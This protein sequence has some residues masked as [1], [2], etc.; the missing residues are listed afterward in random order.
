[1]CR[2]AGESSSRRLADVLSTRSKVHRNSHSPRHCLHRHFLAR[3]QPL[4][5]A[6]AACCPP[7]PPSAA[8]AAAAARRRP[9]PPPPPPPPPADGPRHRPRLVPRTGGRRRA[10]SSIGRHHRPPHLAAVPPA[11]PSPA[12]RRRAAVGAV[13]SACTDFMLGAPP[14]SAGAAIRFRRW[15][16]PRDRLDA[17]AAGP[18]QAGARRADE[19]SRRRRVRRAQGPRGPW[20]PSLV[21][22]AALVAARSTVGASLDRLPPPGLGHAAGPSVPRPRAPAGRATLCR[23]RRR[24]AAARLRFRTCWR[25]PPAAPSP[26]RAAVPLPR[27]RRAPSAAPRR[28]ANTLGRRGRPSPPAPA[29][30]PSTEAHARDGPRRV[31]PSRRR[32]REAVVCGTSDAR[33]FRD[34]LGA[35]PGRSRD[36]EGAHLS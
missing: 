25:R 34:R 2:A 36:D 18:L 15:C 11:D 20:S 14:R 1:M 32:S 17:G 22:S 12:Q 13:A 35:T 4:P 28:S 19:R 21:S 26:P 23:R 7:P 29:A 27:A 3:P 10:R 30:T 8:A 31:P 16:A 9:P 6:T 5:R 24:P 33:S